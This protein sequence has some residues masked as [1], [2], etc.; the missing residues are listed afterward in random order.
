L[1]CYQLAEANGNE[2]QVEKTS[3][4]KSLKTKAESLKAKVKGLKP[5]KP[6][7]NNS[8]PSVST[9]GK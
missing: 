3:H 9:D 4:R 7:G 8:L 5:A 6:L 1:N 2:M